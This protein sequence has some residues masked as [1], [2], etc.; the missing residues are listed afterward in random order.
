[1]NTNL[2]VGRY[3]SQNCKWPMSEGQVNP[4]PTLFSLSSSRRRPR[5]ADPCSS[6]GV[7]Q[8]ERSADT[9][10]LPSGHGT[11]PARRLSLGSRRWRTVIWRA[12][13]RRMR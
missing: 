8:T 11:V 5:S 2:A 9:D 13:D 10:D 6:Y 4:R 12:S 1:M 3:P 7:S